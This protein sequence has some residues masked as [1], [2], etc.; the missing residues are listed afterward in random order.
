MNRCCKSE[1]NTLEGKNML[2]GRVSGQLVF[3]L[4]TNLICPSLVKDSATLS[5]VCMLL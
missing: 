1:D 3:K 2:L 4:D 5:T